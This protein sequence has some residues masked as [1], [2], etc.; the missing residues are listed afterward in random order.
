VNRW[1]AVLLL[2]LPLPAAQSR[3]FD[4]NNVNIDDYGVKSNGVPRIAQLTGKPPRAK[5]SPSGRRGAARRGAAFRCCV[6]NAFA[7]PKGIGAGSFRWA[8]Q[9]CTGRLDGKYCDTGLVDATGR[10]C[11]DLVES[12]KTTH[13]RLRRVPVGEEMPFSQRVALD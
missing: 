8:E 10:S 1:A 13:R 11:A 6:E 2:P 3:A 4:N 9:S 5:S 12:L 7:L